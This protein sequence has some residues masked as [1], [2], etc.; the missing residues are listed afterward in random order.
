MADGWYWSCVDY[1][2]LLIDILVDG[3]VIRRDGL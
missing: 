3:V 2:Q 1:R